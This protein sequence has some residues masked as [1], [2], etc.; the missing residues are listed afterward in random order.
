MKTIYVAE[1]L[2]DSYEGREILVGY[3]SSRKKAEDAV[4]IA[5]KE[6]K[7]EYEED[8]EEWD[9]DLYSSWIRP[10]EVDKKY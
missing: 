6:L 1:I 8:D 10:Y 3:F 4:A 7:E 5:F 9:D 2:E